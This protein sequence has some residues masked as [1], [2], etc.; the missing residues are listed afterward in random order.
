[1]KTSSLARCATGACVAIAI[2][3]G[4]TNG[5]TQP[6]VGLPGA[7][8]PPSTL[9]TQSLRH[10]PSLPGNAGL[11][12]HPDHGKSWMAPDAKK[13]DLLYISD[14]GAG[15]VYVYSYPKS[16][17][18]KYPKLEGTLTGFDIPQ[19]DCADKAGNV[20]ITN[21]VPPEIVEYAHGGTSPIATLSDSGYP[22]GCSV[23]PTTGNLAVTN[24][25][26]YPSCGTGSVAIYVDAVGTPTLYTD[27]DITSYFFD[28]YDNKGNLFVDGINNG[29][30]QFAELPSG[31]GTFTNISLNESIGY[32]GGVQWVGTY[33]AVENQDTDV[34]YQFTLSGSGGTEIGSTTLNG[35]CDVPTFWIKG[36]TV[37]APDECNIFVGLW[38]YPAGGAPT[39]TLNDF[40]QPVGA[41][42]SKGSK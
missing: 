19:G 21:Q 6:Q 1:M 27:P 13:K 39:K 4:C 10:L 20:W 25:C 24:T 33:V 28:S 14:Q 9:N 26:S 32:P 42:L 16:T 2:L 37:V 23:D 17:G 3:G 41:V 7:I 11:V 40:S 36:K 18:K 15:A 38:N 5:G 8:Q 29:P 12:R 31:S 30:F 22:A 35:T 34:I